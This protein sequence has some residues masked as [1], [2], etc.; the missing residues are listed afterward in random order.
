M[1]LRLWAPDGPE[2]LIDDLGPV[3]YW[4]FPPDG[5]YFTNEIVAAYLDVFASL[6]ADRSTLIALEVDE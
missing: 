1:K 5:K 2:P 4:I 3:P 6:Q